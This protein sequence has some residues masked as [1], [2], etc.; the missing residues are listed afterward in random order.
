MSIS[1][2]RLTKIISTLKKRNKKVCTIHELS[3]SV[4]IKEDALKDFFFSFNPLIY[5]EENFNLLDLL[6]DLIEEE[7]AIEE[8]E[9]S[10]G[11]KTKKKYI[12]QKDLAPYKDLIDYIYQTCTVDG[13]IL[14]TGYVL[15][16][17]DVKIISKLLKEEKQR[18]KNKAEWSLIFNIVRE[19]I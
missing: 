9:R 2:T 15:N 5:F 8:K 10:K 13:G 6:D 17:K 12:R 18:I 1:K 4:G 14:D 11:V 7:K 19:Y 16:K 3:F